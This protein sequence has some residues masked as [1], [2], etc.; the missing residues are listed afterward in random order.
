[1]L[2]QTTS[3]TVFSL[4]MGALL[5]VATWQWAKRWERRAAAR[6]HHAAASREAVIPAV[7]VG[8][9][10]PHAAHAL[11]VGTFFLGISPLAQLLDDR[12]KR[13]F[14]FRC[15]LRCVRPVRRRRRI[16]IVLAS[17]GTALFAAAFGFIGLLEL[18]STFG[19]WF[20][21]QARPYLTAHGL[22]PIRQLYCLIFLFV[23]GVALAAVGLWMYAYSPF[24]RVLDAGGDEIYFHFRSQ[25]FRNQFARLNGEK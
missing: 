14:L 9:R 4:L 23:T 13:S 6:D 16:G 8:C 3:E 21:D 17:V 7:C 12:F 20:L 24:V 11:T 15:C 18:S 1:M 22:K 19:D 25:L 2:L 5:S 10:S